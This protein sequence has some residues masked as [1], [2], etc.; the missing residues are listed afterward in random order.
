MAKNTAV[1]GLYPSR[2]AVESAVMAFQNAGYRPTDI[3][4]L[5]PQNIGNKDLAVEKNPI[6]RAQHPSGAGTECHS[7]ARAKIGGVFVET[8]GQL[9]EIITRAQVQGQV[10]QQGKMVLHEGPIV[11]DRVIRAGIA[12]RLD[13]EIRGTSQEVGRAAEKVEA[14]EAIQHGC[15]RANTINRAAY[16]PLVATFGSKVGVAPLVVVF[17]AAAVPGIRLPE[18]H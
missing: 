13:E 15:A 5:L 9:L 6:A 3:S 10:R 16:L 7:N 17:P 8:C 14:P 2:A 1:F 11:C 12:E 4:L 18:I